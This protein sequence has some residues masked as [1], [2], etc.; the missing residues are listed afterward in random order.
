MKAMIF[1]AGLG[2]RLRPLTENIPKALVRIHGRTMM[3]RVL[4]KLKSSGFDEVII[5]LNHHAGLIR[6]YLSENKNFGLSI[7][8]SDE[9]DLL[10]DTGGGLKKARAFFNDGNPFLVHNIDILSNIDLR[11]LYQFHLQYNPTAT[12]ALQSRKTDRVLLFDKDF[13]LA[14]WKN[15]ATGKIKLPVPKEVVVEM[16]FCGIHVISPEIFSHMKRD[17]VFS[18]I[19]TYMDLIPYRSIKGFDVKDVYWADIG[20]HHD[21][22]EVEKYFSEN[23]I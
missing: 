10:L 12:L 6:E 1:A 5:N 15:K 14:G 3:D 18:I 23:N 21:L 4:E 9:S 16:G 13:N 11:E 20:N 17:G 2:T 7:S 19:D 8:I 22:A